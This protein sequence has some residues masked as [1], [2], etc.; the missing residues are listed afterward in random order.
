MLYNNKSFFFLTKQRNLYARVKKK[1][2]KTLF[3]FLYS[4]FNYNILYGKRFCLNSATSVDLIKIDDDINFIKKNF[5]REYTFEKDKNKSYFFNLF[6]GLNTANLDA[7]DIFYFT[8]ELNTYFLSNQLN[9]KD[10]A[11]LHS[12]QF[13]TVNH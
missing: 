7:K 2:K 4:K 12:K 13:Q 1:K 5:D 3:I 10:A 9:N 11:F 8:K 6:T